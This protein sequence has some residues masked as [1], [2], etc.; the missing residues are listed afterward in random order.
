MQDIKGDFQ[1]IVTIVAKGYS[2]DVI[3][4]ST[5]AGATGG[6]ILHGR[7]SGVH[8]KAKFFNIHIEPEKEIVLTL[9]KANIVDAVLESISQAVSIEKPNHGIAFVMDVS[10]VIGICHLLECLK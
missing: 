10:K 6:T 3:D 8:E 7:G 2:S 1:L 4:A 5:A 9:C